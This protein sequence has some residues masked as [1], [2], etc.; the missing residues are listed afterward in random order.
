MTMSK[1]LLKGLILWLCRRAKSILHWKHYQDF[2]NFQNPSISGGTKPSCLHVAGHHWTRPTD[3]SEDAFKRHPSLHA[4]RWRIFQKS[5]LRYCKVDWKPPQF[6]THHH[7]KVTWWDARRTRNESRM[8]VNFLY[9]SLYHIQRTS[10]W[11]RFFL[12][13]F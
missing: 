3:I 2:I 11:L 12:S 6:W 8:W 4:P 1:K 9:I 13:I 10:N 5:S 7:L